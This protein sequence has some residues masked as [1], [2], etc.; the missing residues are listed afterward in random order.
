MNLLILEDERAAS[1][2]MLQL[3]KELE[4]DAKV[5]A[6]LETV[7]EA[8]DWLNSHA[9]P[10]LIISDIQL[11]DGVCFDIF[12]GIE[13]NTP[14]IFTTAYDAYMLKAFKVNSIDYLLKPIDKEELQAALAKYHSLH[15]AKYDSVLNHKLLEMIQQLPVAA[16]YRSRFLVKQGEKLISIASDEIAYLRADDKLV[17]LHT[18][19]GSK[20]IIDESL[21]DLEIVLDPLKFFR[22]NR[23]YIA[24]IET[25]E[26]IHSHFNGRLKIDLRNCDD[27]DIFV[28]KQRAGEFKKWLNK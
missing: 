22:I 26:K 18:I 8:I 10:D 6:I 12:S 17:F 25:I 7:K 3:L 13:V 14:V 1:K 16:S 28:S 11:A 4:P 19:K 5:I 15:A 27:K 20:H 9:A 23:T 24:P 21:N 2:R